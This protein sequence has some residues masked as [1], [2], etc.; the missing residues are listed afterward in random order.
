MEQ[1]LLE[2]LLRQVENKEVMDHS[3]HGFSKGKSCLTNLVAFYDV[4]TALADKGRATD[5]NYPDLGKV[6]DTVPHD[7]LVSK[8]ERRGFD[9]WTTQRIRNWLN[10][11]TQRV[12]VSGSISKWKPEMNGVPLGSVLGLV[13]FNI[14]V[15]NMDS[16]IECPLSKFANDSK[17]CGAVDT[18]EGRDAIQR[19]LDRL[20]SLLNPELF[21]LQESSGQWLSV[22]IGIADKWCPSGVQVLF[23]VFIND[24]DSGIECTF[25]KFADGTKLS[26]AVDMPE[27]QD[28]IQRD[29]DK[30]ERWAHVNLMRFN[31]AKCRVLHLGWGN[32]QYQYRLGDEGTESSPAEEDLGVLDEKLDVSQQYALTAQK[33]NHILGCIKRSVASRLWEVI[34]PLCSGETPT[35]STVSS[36]GA[37]STGRTWTFGAGPAEGHKDGQRTGAPML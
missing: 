37:L 28:A 16:G 2:S 25:S 9:P 24:I 20:E 26:G 18:L 35:W 27:G 5:I 29:L 3:Q 21:T 7:I 6:F 22:Q 33:A 1:I 13:L 34:L 17:L 10:G 30:L 23:N 11:H 8:L 12:A 32:P 14:T 36:S 15:G 19:D 4:A 31:K